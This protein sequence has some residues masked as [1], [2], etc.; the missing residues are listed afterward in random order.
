MARHKF[1]RL[2]FISTLSAP[3]TNTT[4]NKTNYL[5]DVTFYDFR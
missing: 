4:A 2:R 5:L 1:F 3:V